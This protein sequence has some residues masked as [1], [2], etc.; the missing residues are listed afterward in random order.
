MNWVETA[1]VAL[2][3]VLSSIVLL[4]K[5]AFWF[6]RLC[7][8]PFVRF[9]RGVLHLALLPLAFLVKFEAILTFVTVA[10]LTG[11]VAGLV[12]HYLNVSVVK[13]L[14]ISPGDHSLLPRKRASRSRKI[15]ASSKNYAT[16]Q[17]GDIWPPSARTMTGSL[18]TADDYLKEWSHQTDPRSYSK[19]KGLLASTILEEDEYS[20]VSGD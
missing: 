19:N 20:E 4:V 9:G 5:Y 17:S 15:K 8:V 10:L 11:I 6:L 1:R 16:H 14:N 2:S 3:L 12:L 7:T 13:V 18:P